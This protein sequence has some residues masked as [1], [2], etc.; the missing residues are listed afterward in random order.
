MQGHSSQPRLLTAAKYAAGLAIVVAAVW[1]LAKLGKN[2]DFVG[3][4]DRGFELAVATVGFLVGCYALRVFVPFEGDSNWMQKHLPKW[5]ANLVCG[6]MFIGI[7]TLPFSVPLGM[8][9][10]CGFK[11]GVIL[12]GLMGDKQSE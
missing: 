7:L 6:V 5:A 4:V 8:L 12:T 1:A 2:S 3:A 11:D 10:G 9:V